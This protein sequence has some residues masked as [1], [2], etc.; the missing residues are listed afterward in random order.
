MSRWIRICTI[1]DDAAPLL[2]DGI[3]SPEDKE[4]LL[5]SL[6]YYVH[7]DTHEQFVDPPPE[8]YEWTRSRFSTDPAGRPFYHNFVYDLSTWEPPGVA[9]AVPDDWRAMFNTLICG[10]DVNYTCGQY[11]R[12]GSV[13]GPS[14]QTDEDLTGRVWIDACIDGES[15]FFVLMGG[16]LIQTLPKAPVPCR[17]FAHRTPE[18]KPYYEDI[19]TGHVQWDFPGS[20]Y[21]NSDQDAPELC[22]L[23]N[24]LQLKCLQDQRFNGMTCRVVRLL[25]GRAVVRLPDPLQQELVVDFMNLEQMRV[26]K[27]VLLHGLASRPELNG[28]RGTVVESQMDGGACKYVVE[29]MELLENEPQLKQLKLRASKVLPLSGIANFQL[30]FQNHGYLKRGHCEQTCFFRDPHTDG[31]VHTFH[32]FLPLEFCAWQEKSKK[33]KWPLL[34]YL[35]GTGCGSFFQSGK[36]YLH[37]TGMRHA[38]DRFVI[39]SP[40]CEW[41][42]KQIP[43][44]WVVRLVQTLTCASWIDYNRVY[45]TGQSMG[46]MST[47]EICAKRPDLF[48]A[49]APVAS[50]HK[51]DR[52][53]FIAGA[54]KGMPTLSLMSSTD[55]TCPLHSEKLSERR[56][57]EELLKAGSTTLQAEVCQVDHERMFEEAYCKT[58][59]L[60]EWLLKW[61]RRS[62]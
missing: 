13:T 58:S 28:K 45:L 41:G 42:W 37:S 55:V 1:P 26:S 6:C 59:F 57:W 61:K 62:S 14:E 34:V 50:Y 21:Q 54:L 44:E 19:E 29:L 17:W 33:C 7:A 40:A 5:E 3:V 49:I 35:H 36:K 48:A 46:G 11:N 38:A 9:Y 32:V 51:A 10:H 4:E 31:Q 20:S 53:E 18:G 27:L 24:A 52:R 16:G 15:R 2:N 22:S 25:P 43:S 47:W 23:C 39:L 30:H 12:A 60:Y 56:L 8:G